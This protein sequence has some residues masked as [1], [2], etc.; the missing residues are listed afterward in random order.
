L[1]KQKK[2]GSEAGFFSLRW[3][4]GEKKRQAEACRFMPLTRK[5][6]D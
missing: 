4:A 6:S 1:R 5:Q 3:C 2:T